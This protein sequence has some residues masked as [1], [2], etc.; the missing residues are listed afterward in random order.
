[1]N[2]LQLFC[3]FSID[4]KPKKIKTEDVKKSKKRKQEDE[5]VFFTFYFIL[6]TASNL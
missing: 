6:W 1:M 5:E 2:Y 4:Y 3:N